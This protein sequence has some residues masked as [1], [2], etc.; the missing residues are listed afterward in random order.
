LDCDISSCGAGG[1]YL[2]GANNVVSN[3]L[4]HGVGLMF[5]SAMGVYGGGDGCQISHNEIY[6]TT[7]SAIGFSGK[8][9]V[10][11]NNLLSQCMKVL[12][13]GAAIYCFGMK[14]SILR[15]NFAH[16]IVDTGGYGASSYYLDEQ[17]EGC[18]V[19]NNVSVDVA[20]PSHNHMATNNVIRHN[21]FISQGDMRVTFPRCS[22]YR[23]DCNVLYAAGAITFEGIGNVVSWSKNLVYSG[24]GKVEGTTLKDYATTG[25]VSGVV[26]DTLVGDPQFRGPKRLDLRYGSHSPAGQLGLKPLDVNKAGRVGKKAAAGA[27]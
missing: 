2:S 4:V 24:T 27:R 7:Y 20:R 3:S 17:C 5:P 14:N 13:D 1:V 11:E 8:E 12:H 9:M 15:N 22:G 10:I 16:D 23:L 6:D 26:G 19:E 25:K 21:V 18:E